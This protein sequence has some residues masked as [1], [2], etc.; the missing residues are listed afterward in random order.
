M[1]S[2]TTEIFEIALK[3]IQNNNDRK[4]LSFALT[5]VNLFNKYNTLVHT[6]TYIIDSCKGKTQQFFVIVILNIL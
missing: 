6:N 1:V 4:Q 3:C 2:L 5:S